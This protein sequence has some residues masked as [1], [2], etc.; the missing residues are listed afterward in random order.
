MDIERDAEFGGDILG[1]W[2]GVLD[3]DDELVCGPGELAVVLDG[4]AVLA[5]FGPGRHKP[6][7]NPGLAEYVE[8]QDAVDVAFVTQRTTVDLEGSLG[9][10]E[11]PAQK[12]YQ[13]SVSSGLEVQVTDAALVVALR[14]ELDEDQ[15]VEDFLIDEVLD[16]ASEALEELNPRL[17]AL[18]AEGGAVP[19]WLEATQR[20]V[21][22]VVRE[23]GLAVEVYGPLLV[24]LDA[25]AVAA[26]GGQLDA[27]GLRPPPPRPKRA[28]GCQQCGAA[29]AP[30][31]KTCSSCGA[32]L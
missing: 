4:D 30:G 5:T 18:V 29:A 11:D 16:A 7:A 27:D 20:R 15:S 25:Q 13:P 9:D 23:L 8:A 22:E 26:A 12:R 19:G 17:A 2:D 3:E 14:D 31:A 28:G 10:F 1:W 32:P 24:Q 6:A 21:N